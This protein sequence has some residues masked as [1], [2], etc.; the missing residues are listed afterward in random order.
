MKRV[1][2]PLL[3]L[4]AVSFGKDVELKEVS[5]TATRTERKTEDVP[6]SVS[7][8]GKEKI[9]NKPMLNLYDAL[10]GVP[11]VNIASRNQGYD[12]RLI[13]RGAGLKATYGVREIMILLNG[14]PITDPDSLTRLDFVDTS[15]IER[16]EVVK[17]PNSTLWGVNAFGGVINVITKSP[18]ERKG[19]FIKLGF[20]DLQH[21]ES[22]PLLLHTHWKG[23]L[24]RL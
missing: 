1:V 14:V 4:G 6:A 18:F 16:V 19:G 12:T 21:T 5:V 7:V 10:Q 8:I 22:Q 20:G 17:G 15:L 11:G 24:L 13:I 3:L 9:Q 2:Y 23:F